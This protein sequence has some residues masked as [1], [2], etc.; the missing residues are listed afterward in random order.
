MLI[1]AQ[2]SPLEI[3]WTVPDHLGTPRMNIRGTGT[4]GGSL[5]SVTRHDYLP[6]GGELFAG[7][8][9]RSSSSHGYEPPSDGVRQKFVAKERDNETGLDF[10]GARYFS[11][12]QGRFTS[13]DPL[14]I[15]ALQRLKPKL[16]AKI[17]ADPANWNG[18]AYAHNNPLS[19]IDPDG[20]LTIIVPGTWNS[21]ADWEK[22]GF[23]KQVEKKFGEAAVVLNN[24][25]MGNTD[26]ARADATKKL[27]DLIASHK[28]APGEKL[29]IVAHSHGGNVVASATNKGLSHKIDTLVTLGT[30]IRTDYKFNGS[31]IG[32]HLNVYSNNDSVQT[33][34]GP[35]RRDGWKIT[36]SAERTLSSP[37]VQNL[38]ATAEAN[39]HSEL[40][41]KPGTW[42]KIV[43]PKI[44]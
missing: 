25:N 30:P 38:D 19:K 15:P 29:N 35:M 17:I 31:M 39:G 36:V 32:Q 16:F 33:I 6:F 22:S 43:E 24:D 14:N 4:D 20:F 26:N 23:R 21:H 3:R 11:L 7:V 40:W 41:T 10:F 2:T 5:A 37:G 1:V 28:F 13:N 34:G 42:D 27:M 44:K 12:T 18:Y 8:G 9:L